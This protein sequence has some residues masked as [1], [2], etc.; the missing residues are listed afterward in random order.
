[1][2]R[3]MQTIVRTNTRKIY[4]GDAGITP[5]NQDRQFCLSTNTPRGSRI[6]MG[7]SLQ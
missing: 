2:L 7:I 6:H 1:L 4:Q 3:G 5:I